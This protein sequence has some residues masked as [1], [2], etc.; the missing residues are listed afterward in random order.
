[1]A[2]ENSEN[3]KLQLWQ[4]CAVYFYKCKNVGFNLTNILNELENFIKI[5]YPNAVKSKYKTILREEMEYHRRSNNPNSELPFVFQKNGN[6]WSLSTDG[7]KWINSNKSTI[8]IYDKYKNSLIPFNTRKIIT[9][10]DLK[11]KIQA[12]DKVKYKR[13]EEKIEKEIIN[14]DL[15]LLGQL[16][17]NAIEYSSLQEYAKNKISAH[18]IPER[19]DLLLVVALVKIAQ[20]KATVW[21]D[22]WKTID[23]IL[24]VKTKFTK[25]SRTQRTITTQHKV[26]RIF[27]NTIDFY[28]NNRNFNLF[29]DNSDKNDTLS[30]A[31]HCFIFEKNENN[32][33]YFNILKR[34]YEKDHNFTINKFRDELIRSHEIKK[35]IKNVITKEYNEVE[36]LL[37]HQVEYVKTKNS[38]LCKQDFF[39]KKLAEFLDENYDLEQH[40]YIL[41]AKTNDKDLSKKPYLKMQDDYK[42][43]LHVP[44]QDINN[45]ANVIIKVK[46][47]V[48][49]ARGENLYLSNDGQNIEIDK[50]N[51]KYIFEDLQVIIN[52]NETSILYE[53]TNKSYRFF[54]K[55]G[56]EQYKL[57]S[58]SR[59]PAVVLLKDNIEI[60][61]DIIKEIEEAYGSGYKIC[62]VSLQDRNRYIEIDNKVHFL[63]NIKNSDIDLD[64]PSIP[65]LTC[66]DKDVKFFKCLPRVIIKQKIV[67]TEVFVTNMLT[68]KFIKLPVDLSEEVV[69]AETGETLCIFDLNKIIKDKDFCKPNTMYKV[70]YNNNVSI[71]FI[72]INDMDI[73]FDK[74][75][76][77]GGEDVCFSINEKYNIIN[78][79]K[80]M[81]LENGLYKY[82]CIRKNNASLNPI[83][84]TIA[85][86]TF[87]IKIPYVKF[88]YGN[89][90][91]GP[92]NLVQQ[93]YIGEHEIG[94]EL[95]LEFPEDTELLIEPTLIVKMQSYLPQKIK[96][97][98]REDYYSIKTALLKENENHNYKKNLE[99]R[100]ETKNKVLS[101]PIGIL[102]NYPSVDINFDVKED[103]RVDIYFRYDVI[104]GFPELIVKIENNEKILDEGGILDQTSISARELADN[105]QLKVSVYTYI[106]G[107]RMDI[108]SKLYDYNRK[109]SDT[110]ILKIK[111]VYLKNSQKC[112]LDYYEIS[113]IKKINDYIFTG[114]IYYNLKN[115]E[116]R[117]LCNIN[118]KLET[119]NNSYILYPDGY[120]DLVYGR[121]GMK[122]QLVSGFDKC[123]IEKFICK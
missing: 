85:D 91:L 108:V 64:A 73:K 66:L 120:C 8:E 46:S 47:G 101:K 49:I 112:D 43:V 57:S 109:I 116:Q 115:S 26:K 16:Q 93:K 71:K 24:S 38:S 23:T 88:S 17:F 65:N 62:L 78:V 55:N 50:G 32:V 7:I 27:K 19:N 117:W 74:D 31:N 70:N 87:Q 68:N 48:E 58:I 113:N 94:N 45:K 95:K 80:P 96:F 6:I 84:F 44:V 99:L 59:N 9:D 4:V 1:M 82:K 20:K 3:S 114:D 35:N 77:F 52:N 34:C 61:G 122:W 42:L 100:I 21:T 39:V 105:D 104:E 83:E 103:G 53:I 54:S 79:E 30:I 10:N 14:N 81:A 56:K 89:I 40:N 97:E 28:N 118:F 29:L 123:N 33:A 69:S 51:Y 11:N 13:L 98:N 22:I 41:Q 2:K 12:A 119:I 76:Y 110:E 18:N 90:D 5:L 72:L 86:T 60:D 75:M 15:Y 111:S 121:I 25:Q 107:V 37:Q 63:K 92:L 102:Y 106:N 67:G 36:R